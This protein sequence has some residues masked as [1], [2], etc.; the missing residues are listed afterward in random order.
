MLLIFRVH[1]MYLMELSISASSVDQS[2][3]TQFHYRYNM[4]FYYRYRG[5]IIFLSLFHMGLCPMKHNYQSFL[6]KNQT[7][8]YFNGSWL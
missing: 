3:L 2:H 6:N 4:L 1:F 7:C 5:P 8:P